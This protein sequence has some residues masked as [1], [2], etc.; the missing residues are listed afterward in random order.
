MDHI[1]CL[2][3]VV[4]YA[5]ELVHEVSS[6]GLRCSTVSWKAAAPFA[7]MSFLMISEP[8][9]LADEHGET[10]EVQPSCSASTGYEV[11]SED[12]AQRLSVG[13]AQ[14]WRDGSSSAPRMLGFAL[15]TWK[16]ERLHGVALSWRGARERAQARVAHAVPSLSGSVTVYRLVV[17]SCDPLNPCFLQTKHVLGRRTEIL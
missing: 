7:E 17:A 10:S 2:V 5:I 11:A 9:K 14:A 12:S 8:Q 16:A 13:S 6:K 4:Q 1:A 15:T 3:V